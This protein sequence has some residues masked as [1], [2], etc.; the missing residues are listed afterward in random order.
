MAVKLWP[1][2]CGI[3]F[4]LL[5]PLIVTTLHVQN[6]S[7]VTAYL[8]VWSAVLV[9][10][11]W[12][13]RATVADQFIP[14]LITGLGSGLLTVLFSPSQE[15]LWG[16]LSTLSVY[17]FIAVLGARVLNQKRRKSA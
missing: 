8:M 5:A 13:G 1:L 11:A 16:V 4:C 15:S 14:A 10:G 7:V 9:G 3:A 12:G 17:G 2:A 6:I